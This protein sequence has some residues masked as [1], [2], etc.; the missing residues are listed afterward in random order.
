[1]R[2]KNIL[3]TLFNIQIQQRS[4]IEYSHACCRMWEWAL[5]WKQYSARCWM[6]NTLLTRRQEN[7]GNRVI[8][9][10][11][12]MKMLSLLSCFLLSVHQAD[13]EEAVNSPENPE[14]HL[15]QQKAFRYIFTLKRQPP[16]SA[17]PPPSPPQSEQFLS[18]FFTHVLLF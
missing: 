13:K 8:G 7:K 15:C 3:K 6:W 14:M 4:V 1:M 12:G 2:F 10:W 11:A 18:L 16:L 17:P 5:S 9:V